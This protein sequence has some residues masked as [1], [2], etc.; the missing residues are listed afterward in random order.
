MMDKPP[1]T[2][3]LIQPES[4]ASNTSYGRF[5]SQDAQ[6]INNYQIN[7]GKPVVNSKGHLRCNYCGITNHPRANCV[8][9]IKDETDGIRREIHPNRGLRPTNHQLSR[10]SPNPIQSRPSYSGTSHGRFNSKDAQGINNYQL[11][12]DGKPIIGTKGYVLCNY[13]GVPSHP[14]AT[15]TTRIRDEE[16][17]IRRDIHPN[18]G[19]I[20][21][22]NQVRRDAQAIVNEIVR[23]RAHEEQEDPLEPKT[24]P[25]PNHVIDHRINTT[26]STNRRSPHL[27]TPQGRT[28]PVSWNSPPK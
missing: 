28:Q 7:D 26:G 24:K 23:K 6:G 13:C 18:R 16:N 4:S 1:V 12:D 21:S 17:G 5:D 15:C 11:T 25:S 9:R 22:G 10:E 19:L 3:N 2:P 27:Q 14:R 8:I 20:P